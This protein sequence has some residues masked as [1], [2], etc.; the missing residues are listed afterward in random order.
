MRN[1]DYNELGEL[2]PAQQGQD[3]SL[4]RTNVL[5]E[6]PG[7]E[8]TGVLTGTSTRAVEEESL[9]PAIEAGNY[10]FDGQAGG[11]DTS[12]DRGDSGMFD[13]FGLSNYNDDWDT[14]NTNTGVPMQ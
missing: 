1:E 9:A 8:L 5:R 14:Y 6:L 10:L 13:D 3:A 4:Q 2:A 7:L 12:F 11:L